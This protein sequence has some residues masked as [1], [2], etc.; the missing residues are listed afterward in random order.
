[1]FPA[2]MRVLQVHNFYQVPGGECA[3]VR[4]EKVLLESG[5]HKVGRFTR[6]S[7]A[8]NG[9]SWAKKAR[10]LAGIPNNCAIGGGVQAAIRRFRPDV[11][12]VHNVFP[13]LSPA[14]YTA[15]HRAG[16]PVV[17]TH[18]NFRVLCPNGLFFTDGRVCESC[19]N[20]LSACIRKKCI[21]GSRILSGLYA[22]AIFRGWRR[23]VFTRDIALHIALNPF[24]AQKLAR[25]GIPESAIRVCGNFVSTFA[26]RAAGKEGYFLY[27]GRLSPEKGLLTL[28]EAARRVHASVKVAGTG[29]MEKEI[30]RYIAD[31]HLGRVE[32]LGFVKGERKSELVRKSL[33]VVIPSEWYENFPIS[34]VE[35]QALGT[36]VIA[37]RIGGLPEIVAHGKTGYLFQ[38]G[39]TAELTGLLE[40]MGAAPDLVRQMSVQ[41][42]QR[43]KALFS[44]ETHLQRLLEI[45]EEAVQR[46]QSP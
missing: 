7:T 30:R 35:A 46:T 37:S 24:F 44:P 8:I 36:P 28:L 32:L 26:D 6:D 45:Y 14:V 20:S 5:G 11:A 9:F 17:Q 12:H 31:N 29:P 39:N 16:V 3:V 15:L 10:M 22:R 4:A 38:P 41:S 2:G 19:L 43:A 25:G 21:K 1:M 23:R 33:A 27:L 40:R 13:M 42:L 34:A 18:H